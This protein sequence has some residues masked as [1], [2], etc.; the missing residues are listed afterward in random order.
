[1]KKNLRKA[2][3]IKQ[4]E[5]AAN[6]AL[7]ILKLTPEWKGAKMIIPFIDNFGKENSVRGYAEVMLDIKYYRN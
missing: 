4:K 5:V 6:I 7:R 3:K 1:M 2:Y